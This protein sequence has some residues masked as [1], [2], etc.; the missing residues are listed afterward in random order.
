MEEHWPGPRDPADAGPAPEPS[1]PRRYQG[2][3]REEPPNGR[4]LRVTA[5]FGVVFLL[6]AIWVRWPRE[7]SHAS[8][9][10]PAVTAIDP[11]FSDSG[12]P[13]NGQLPGGPPSVVEGSISYEAESATLSGKAAIVSCPTCLGGAKVRF[14]GAGT[15]NFVTIEVT[16][17]AAGTRHL[18][19]S[20]EVQ[21]SRT[22][23]L[24]VNGGAAV[25][26]PV[27]GAS[28]T[29]PALT[30]VAVVLRAGVNTL[31]FSNASAAAPDLDQVTI[32]P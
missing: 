7:T 30:T 28:L 18:V 17:A 4:L 9:Q 20:Y 31:K 23:V 25:K 6:V 26:V 2:R 21:G 14:I 5:A 1:A 11:N 13:P 32:A 29:K 12:L 8:P 16:A 10:R 24:N 27:R 19:I 3:H 15:R 22:F